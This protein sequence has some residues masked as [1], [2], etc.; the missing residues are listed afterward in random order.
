M[1]AVLIATLIILLLALL[2]LGYFIVSI[3][4]PAG[5]PAS[6]ADAVTGLT[7]VRSIYGYG[8]AA[9]QQFLRPLDAAVSP[10]GTI[11][12]SDKQRDRVLGFNSNASPA[13]VIQRPAV[14]KEANPRLWQPGG[15]AVGDDGSLYVVDSRNEKVQVYTKDNRFLRE[16]SVPLPSEVAV[17]NGRVVVTSIPGVSVFTTDGK[18]LSVW[19][20][21]GNGAEEFDTPNGVAIAGDDTVY[22]SDSLNARVKA[23]RPDGTLKWVWPKER[24]E[25][26]ST[27]IRPSAG[28]AQLQIPMG[29]TLDGRG[30]IVLA[31]AFSFELV[32][33]QPSATGAKL[34]GRYGGFGSQDGLFVYPSGVDYDP[35]RDYFVVADTGNDR[36]QVVRLPGS[37]APGL[38]AAA[39]RLTADV[40]PWCALPLVLLLL[41]IVLAL[42]RRSARDR[43]GRTTEAESDE[44]EDL[45]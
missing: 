16:W 44:Q 19:G 5:A 31:D 45:G 15:V 40:S 41:V 43:V 42:S 29:L 3:L 13:S 22:I 21:R 27:G 9:S 6:R 11:W 32:V 12:G 10:D 35:A 34:V 2:G 26:T 17:R 38:G 24:T 30:R 36:L 14:G 23:Y 37:A 8:P 33:L 7:W 25:A 4:T 20:K 1:R 39:R 18:L 28:A